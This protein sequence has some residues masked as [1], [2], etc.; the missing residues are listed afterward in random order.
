MEKD[1][2]GT[3]FSST[4]QTVLLHFDQ[5]FERMKVTSDDDAGYT[6]SS[7]GS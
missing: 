1:L 5:G 6:V 7:S 4:V 3:Y 2:N